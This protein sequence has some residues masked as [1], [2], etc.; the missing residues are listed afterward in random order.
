MAIETFRVATF[1]AENLLHPG[2]RFLGR[3]DAGYK[4]TEYDEKIRWMRGILR[5]GRVD[6]VG[7][8]EQFSARALGHVVQGLGL[9]HVYAP[10][11][12]G[13]KNIR[14]VDGELRAAGPFVALASR[15]KI[16]EATSIVEFP[17]AT[18]SLRMQGLESGSIIELPLTRF[19][20]PV[21]HAKV[22]LRPGVIAS[23]FVAH[24]KSKRPQ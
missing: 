16:V 23:V 21:I 19:Q 6:L 13:D 2:V 14:A 15:F 5:D 10:D 4:Q 22:E 9:E 18:R 12:E 20:R 3:P 11:L 7:F 8:Q 17:E 1:N 24:L